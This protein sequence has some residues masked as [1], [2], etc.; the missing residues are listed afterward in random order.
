MSFIL[1]EQVTVTDWGNIQQHYFFEPGCFAAIKPNCVALFKRF[2]LY[3]A[4]CKQNDTP[5]NKLKG[6]NYNADTYLQ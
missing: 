3:S 6:A 5:C 1:I 2:A 4:Q